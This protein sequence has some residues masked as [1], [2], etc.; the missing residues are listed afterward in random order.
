MAE[1]KEALARGT[2]VSLPPAGLHPE[3]HSAP[4]ASSLF[5]SRLPPIGPVSPLRQRLNGR[6]SGAAGVSFGF[7]LC[8]STHPRPS[9]VAKGSGRQLPQQW[10]WPCT[11]PPLGRLRPSTSYSDESRWEPSHKDHLQTG[12]LSTGQW[13]LSL[14]A[15]APAGKMSPALFLQA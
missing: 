13:Q 1:R 12:G 4:T 2:L 5:L 11:N 10:S 8:D 3:L 15:L 6:D 14:C 7:R 9:A